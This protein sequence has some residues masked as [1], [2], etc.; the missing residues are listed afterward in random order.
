MYKPTSILLVSPFWPSDSRSGVSL[1]AHS[2]VKMLLN[3]GYFVSIVGPSKSVYMTKLPVSKAYKVP[4][5]GSGSL[6]SMSRINNKQVDCVINQSNADI[7]VIEAWQTTL[8]DTFIYRSKLAG[9]PVLLIS[10]G[11]SVHAFSDNLSDKLRALGWLFYA[12]FKLPFLV[13]ALTGITTLSLKSESSRFFDRELAKNNHIPIFPLYNSPVNY[14]LE[15]IPRSNRKLQI[16]IIGYYSYIKNQLAVIDIVKEF[17][18]YDITFKFIGDKKGK[19]YAKCLK[20]VDSEKLNDYVEFLDDTEC[21]LSDEIS[22]SLAII[23]TS[24]TEALPIT[25]IES[26]ACGTPFVAP[27]VG[28]IPFLDGGVIANVARTRVESLKRIINNVEFWEDLSLKG[29]KCYQENYHLKKNMKML[30][31][32]VSNTIMLFHNRLN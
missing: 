13:R 3:M 32:A 9:K 28:A 20:R 2:H 26:M 5:K 11:I 4:S 19:Y 15:M 16:L 8:S 18:K 10:H 31:N 24:I 25:L 21:N 14:R 22:Q 27:S 17:Q 7:V 30:D 1:S 6:Y 29:R 23:S 12:K